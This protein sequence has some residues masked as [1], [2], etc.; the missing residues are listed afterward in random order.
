M[1]PETCDNT[2]RRFCLNAELGAA[3]L[4]R[5]QSAYAIKVAVAE[6]LVAALMTLSSLCG[7]ADITR[8]E[9]PSP[10]P[11]SPPAATESAATTPTT[12]ITRAPSPSD[13]LNTLLMHATFRIVGPTDVPNQILFG[14]VFV[15]G[16]PYKDNPKIAHIVVVTA[17]HVFE[18]ISGNNATLQLRRKQADGTYATFGYQLP[19][20]AGAKP[21][22]V[23]HPAAD[24]AAM[25]GDI[26]DEVPM[27]GLSPD[28][29][30]TDMS[31]EEIEFHPGD[32]AYILGFPAMAGTEGGFPLL[33]TGR[34]A[35]YPLTPMSVVKQWAFDAH[36]F[37]GNSGGPVY[38]TSVNRLFKNQVH[39][40]VARGILGLVTQERHS[41]LPEFAQRDLD[42]GVV[43]P[44]Q[45]IRETLDML[46]PAP[47]EPGGQTQEQG[48]TGSVK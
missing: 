31:L 2:R 20:R 27:T 41:N 32:E 48:G 19:I 14:S 33:R 3:I 26:P 4:R 44:A 8:A 9:P 7:S 42:Y 25:Y 1:G 24:V 30:V 23:R 11:E 29:L 16:L 5:V 21:L 34:I 28:F 43:V 12:T 13:E 6:W 40:G 18:G 38:F 10:A 47:S 46:P 35:S 15:M 22:Y 45:F 36:V 39:L 17:A 37:N